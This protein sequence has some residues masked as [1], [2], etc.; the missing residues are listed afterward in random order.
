MS[1][2]LT[3]IQVNKVFH[4]KDFVIEL[5]ANEKRHLILTGKNGSGK[6][7]LLN[8]IAEFLQQIKA[9]PS[10]S[11]LKLEDGLKSEEHQ[12]ETFRKIGDG[13]LIRS[14]E[15]HIDTLK[16]DIQKIFGKVNL[17][18]SDN[19]ELGRK[20]K[21]QDFLLSFYSATRKTDV[22][23]P[24]NPEKPNL[25]PV[26]NI[27]DS[28][29]KEFLKFLVD[30]KVQEALARNENQ[31]EAANEIKVW[32]E[33]FT[34]LLQKLFE[35]DEV[36]LDFNYKNYSFTINQ[37]GRKFGF[38][39]LSDGYSAIIV[40]IADLIIK[41]QDQNSLTRAY[42]KEGIVLIDEIETHLH[43]KLQRL[44]LPM[45][46]GIF[47]NIQFIVTTHSPFV[48]NSLKN[49]VAFDL[50]KCTRLENLTEYSYE[51][52]AEGY[53]KVETDS[54]FL[55]AK[56]ER[57]QELSEITEKDTAELAEYNSL[58][59]EFASLDEMLTSP[60]IKGQYLQIKLN[61]K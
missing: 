53:F 44:I 55:L 29:I 13:N 22:V 15:H 40:I 38:N 34:A 39:E 6:T 5:D 43:L 35:G 60:N 14:A 26:S 54:N 42:E 10:L 2:F 61:S 27:K 52:L 17:N 51:A 47:P 32:F 18:F 3:K 36:T 25:Q 19:L 30:L 33:S 45:L 58:D 59:G 11:F 16:N 56:L 31:N 41:M 24:K 48:L 1:T 37:G 9:N 57:F 28:K 4:L 46:T 20:V 50:E 8:G 49:A 23:I 21:D 12:L 7:S